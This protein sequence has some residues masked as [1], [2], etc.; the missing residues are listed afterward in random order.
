MGFKRNFFGRKDKK[1]PSVWCKVTET[2]Q[3][4]AP[5]APTPLSDRHR[6]LKRLQLHSDFPVCILSP[7]L[8]NQS[9]GTPEASKIATTGLVCKGEVIQQVHSTNI[10]RAP[11]MFQHRDRGSYNNSCL[12]YQ[13]NKIN[14]WTLSEIQHK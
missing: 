8:S 11:S 12:G 10:C 4:V 7:P 14:Q 5:T 2:K 6:S 1:K 9:S 3:H 13:P